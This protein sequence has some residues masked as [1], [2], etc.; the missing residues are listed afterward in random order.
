MGTGVFGKRFTGAPTAV[1]AMGLLLVGCSA[2][3]TLPPAEPPVEAT[4]DQSA[5]AGPDP[6]ALLS[7][8]DRSTAGLS[9]PGRPKTI[10]TN[11][12]CDWTEPGTFGLTVTVAGSTPLSGLHVPKGTAERLTVGRHAAIKVSGATAGDG[13]CAML[14]SAGENA[15][16]QVDVTNS[17][18]DDTALACRRASTVAGLI[19]PGLP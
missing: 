12:A 6:C 15:S 19:E 3:A 16:V 8:V 7:T 11:R 18:F 4:P 2:Q 1:A 17:G 9:T 13:T 14:L 10:G 5:P